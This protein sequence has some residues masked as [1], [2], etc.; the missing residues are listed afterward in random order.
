MHI[1][2]MYIV[3]LYYLCRTNLSSETKVQ[4][5]NDYRSCKQNEVSLPQEKDI[6]ETK[7]SSDNDNYI[8]TVVNYFESLD[9]ATNSNLN[10]QIEFSKQ[11]ESNIRYEKKW[12]N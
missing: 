11:Q 1:I 2:L 8:A 4:N 12:W 10:S 5:I 6:K 7:P 9:I 3:S